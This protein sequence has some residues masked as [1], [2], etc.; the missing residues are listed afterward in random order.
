MKIAMVLIGNSYRVPY[1]K[2]YF[3]K[4]SDQDCFEVIYWDRDG[5]PDEGPWRSIS[6]NCG[7][8]ENNLIGKVL[9]YFQ[10]RKFLLKV[11]QRNRY[12]IVIVSPTNTALLLGDYLPRRFNGRYI[13]DIRDYCHE[14][15][16]PVRWLE[17]LLVKHA[18]LTVISS[19]GY[20]EFLP[21]KGHYITIH[22]N[23]DIDCCKIE[24]ARSMRKKRYPIRIGCIG[25]IVYHS[26]YEQLIEQFKN[27]ERFRLVFIGHGSDVLDEYCQKHGIGN[28]EIEGEFP[29]EE[30]IEK[31]MDIDVVNG[32]Y[33]KNHP[34]LDYALS[35]KLYIAASLGIPVLANQ[36]TYMEKMVDRYG[37]GLGIDWTD[38]KSRDVLFRYYADLDFE[39]LDKNCQ[40][41]LD[42]VDLDNKQFDDA[43]VMLFRNMR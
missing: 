21:K 12:D 3:D 4:I 9:G 38:A 31:F 40:V 11:L 6:F 10:Y 15:F 2:K 8:P 13:F 30:T 36:N 29:P 37:I 32:I 33:G 16:M 24:A 18:A 1:I 26:A 22:N 41:F 17:T 19:A 43:V 23:R 35:N 7:L 27:D 14:R 39:M 42:A 28:V 25:S 34:S 5:R 20:R